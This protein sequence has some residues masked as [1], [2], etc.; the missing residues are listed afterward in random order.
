MPVTFV[1]S[2]A[3][4]A[5]VLERRLNLAERRT[6]T[7]AKYIILPASA[8]A[9]WF[10][11]PRYTAI[12]KRVDGVFIVDS[13][14]MTGDNSN[15]PTETYVSD[16]LQYIHWR[17]GML[18]V[19]CQCNGAGYT[20]LDRAARMIRDG[21]DDLKIGHV[22]FCVI[23]SMGNDIY[24]RAW[25]DRHKRAHDTQ[26]ADSVANGMTRV[27]VYS[28]EFLSKNTLVVYGGTSEVWG[29][30]RAV[31]AGIEHVWFGVKYNQYVK[32]VLKQL[33]LRGVDCI[34]G[35][36]L[37]PVRTIDRI[38]HIHAESLN[39]VVNAYVLWARLAAGMPL[40]DSESATYPK[41]K[42]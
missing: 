26:L 14:G 13:F 11:K 16:A 42:L 37:G 17:T 12:H 33:R 32:E 2:V 35:I 41:S 18:C 22:S 34:A 38:G 21:L 27:F 40:R 3:I 15:L 25:Y 7:I 31:V 36:R 30:D 23:I 29:Y 1:Q 20:E 39:V 9:P 19:A 8:M 28:K 4:L 10:L 6:H 5:R 24:S